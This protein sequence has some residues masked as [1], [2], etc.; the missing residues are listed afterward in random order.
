MDAVRAQ[1][2]AF[3][4]PDAP[5]RT[6]GP[7]DWRVAEGSFTLLLGATGCGKT[8]LLRCLKPTLAPAGAPEG[9]LE[10]LGRAPAA[11]GAAEGAAQVGYV[12][13]NPENQLVCDTV[14]HELAFGLENVG[15]GQDAMRR[16]VAEVAHFFG[17]E[18]WFRASVADL[19]GGQQ[20]MVNLAAVL[21]LQ[22]RLLVLDEP[23]AQ[24]DPVAEKNFLH[25]LF[26]VNR[27]LGI[28]VVMATHAP[29]ATAPYATDLVELANGQVRPV[30]VPPILAPVPAS[31]PA[32][33]RPLVGHALDEPETPPARRG[34]RGWRIYLLVR[35]R[36]A[37][38]TGITPIPCGRGCS[39]APPTR[40]GRTVCSRKTFSPRAKRGSP[41][42]RPRGVSLPLHAEGVTDRSESLS[43]GEEAAPRPTREAS[44][45]RPFRE[46]PPA[47][48]REALPVLSFR[49]AHFRYAREDGWVLRGLDLDVRAGDVHAAV[50]GNG[51]GKSTL[52][53]L[54]A[55]VLKPERGRVANRLAARQ[56][57]LP[58]NPKAL[59]VCD[60]VADELREWQRGC[61]YGD[62]AVDAALERFSLAAHVAR[63]PYDLSGG[64]QQL[65]AFA[66]ILL[67]DPDLLLLD[68]PT[69]GL[70]TPTKCALAG[71]VRACAR[72][73]ATVVLVTHDLAFA[74]RVA[75]RATMLFDGEAACTE[76][77]GEFFAGNL[78]YRPVPD[79]FFRTWRDGAEAGSPGSSA[80]APDG[81]TAR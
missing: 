30:A 28:T 63:H 46:A 68:E 10:G 72:R 3:T 23:T 9:A 53:R 64:Q 16:R 7:L 42:P 77:A 54:A 57:L 25:A 33:P 52:L 8:T 17:I 80:P 15:L 76:P 38:R 20:Q 61:C 21:A 27:E 78:F 69:K 22:P 75:D 49:D 4:Y 79:A 73:G 81:G 48:T 67:T 18:P 58:Q 74:A 31:A 26:R 40:R 47:A 51:C 70:D 6:F 56:A 62:D 12:A 71:A 44:S 39:F 24:L 55:G 66:K 36:R 45:A 2:F 5:A 65:L 11:F 29:E 13:Q 32:A 1:G 41:A 34:E 35:R 50:G 59:F 37:E 43:L 14:W 60:T 19:S